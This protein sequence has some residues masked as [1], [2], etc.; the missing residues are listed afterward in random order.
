MSTHIEAK[1]VAD[2][3]FHTFCCELQE[4]L[5]SGF[6]LDNLNPP[7]V[8]FS[9]RGNLYEASLVKREELVDIIPKPTRAEIL[10]AAKAEVKKVS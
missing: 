2:M 3:S 6:V 9:Q 10:A 7:S 5:L 1:Q 8:L 4:A